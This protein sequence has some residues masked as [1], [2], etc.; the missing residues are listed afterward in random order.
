MREAIPLFHPYAFM[1]WREENFS[2]DT[3]GLALE[4]ELKYT[5][6]S[7]SFVALLCLNTHNDVLR[8]F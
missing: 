1:P 8:L 3:T 4:L 5:I 2:L 6:R 7:D